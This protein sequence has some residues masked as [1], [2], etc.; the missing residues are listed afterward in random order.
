VQ[1]EFETTPKWQEVTALAYPSEVP[2]K[3]VKPK[4]EKAKGRNKGQTPT[5]GDEQAA[6]LTVQDATDAPTELVKDQ[7]E[8]NEEN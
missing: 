3:V 1:K 4:K 2:A 5:A 6:E 8:K 7:A